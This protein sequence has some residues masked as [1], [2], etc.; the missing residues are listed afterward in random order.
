LSNT[1]GKVT[2]ELTTPGVEDGG[3]YV[4][5]IGGAVPPE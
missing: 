2:E 3:V 5:G 4:Y 1:H